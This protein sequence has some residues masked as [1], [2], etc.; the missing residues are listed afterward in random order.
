MKLFA[1]LVLANA[2]RGAKLASL[3]PTT[4]GMSRE[5]LGN[6]FESS[7][8]IDSWTITCSLGSTVP[9][10]I[11]TAVLDETI[12]TSLHNE[13]SGDVLGASIEMNGRGAAIIECGGLN[14]IE[15]GQFCG[16][17]AEILLV[18]IYE[19]D[20]GRCLAATANSVRAVRD[21]CR[22]RN[23]R[24]AVIV[25]VHPSADGLSSSS[26][27]TTT[28]L[29]SR[30]QAELK[31]ACD[32]DFGF[33]AYFDGI[34]SSELTLALNKALAALE[35]N[36]ALGKNSKDK[37]DIT[38]SIASA[39][40]QCRTNGVTSNEAALYACDSAIAISKGIARLAVNRWHRDIDDGRLAPKG[41][42][43]EA[44]EIYRDCL[45]RYDLATISHWR[46]PARGQ[47]RIQ[48]E[49]Y[50]HDEIKRCHLKQLE[51]ASARRLRKLRL[52]LEH[53]AAKDARGEIDPV[54]ADSLVADAELAFDL[55]ATRCCVPSIDLLA[56]DARANFRDAAK[57][58]AAD[59]PDTPAAQLIAAKA[60][61]RAAKK[62]APKSKIKDGPAAKL[63]P[64]SIKKPFAFNY[65]V[66]L[67]GMLR[68]KGFG[69]M[70][71]FINYALGP[72]S[73]LFGYSDDRDVSGDM[74]AND[75]IPLLRLQP[76][77]TLDLDV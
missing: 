71:A 23:K 65:A 64:K 19:S 43:A 72:H 76:K 51:L 6:L 75:D 58:L 20:L 37:Y 40:E 67:V 27:T 1:F 77:I 28:N 41:W 33:C 63:A 49:N 61:E 7:E 73:I 21:G 15:S 25:V 35:T 36:S 13:V 74:Q 56:A 66:Q 8:S 53:S 48:L 17:C 11:R 34:E 38:E 12:G 47:I 50:L 52:S 9:L 16:S 42:A 4:K 10:A 2:A 18:H 22:S 45:A 14:E 39:F 29:V 70:Q 46:D 59:F 30:T 26:T 31:A 5:R 68:P 54:I 57:R 3:S 32:G 69:N 60:E 44:A 55:D 24:I 62:A